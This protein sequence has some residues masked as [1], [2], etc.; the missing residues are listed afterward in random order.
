MDNSNA[1]TEQH[2]QQDKS[3]V[4]PKKAYQHLME[5][6]VPASDMK[7]IVNN[8]DGVFFSRQGAQGVQIKNNIANTDTSD[9]A[10]DNGNTATEEMK[11]VDLDDII[12]DPQPSNLSN[13]MQTA[14]ET[15]A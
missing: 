7:D 10:V 8:E 6:G 9:L 15:H 12:V 14:P 13:A 1:S 5:D 3:N 11:S 2:S 4:Q